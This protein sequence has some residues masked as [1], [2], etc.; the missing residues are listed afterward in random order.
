MVV[1]DISVSITD[2]AKDVTTLH[3]YFVE[4]IISKNPS[5]ANI[6]SY[7]SMERNL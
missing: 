2:S 1:T 5:R 3:T 4:V 6:Y 7:G